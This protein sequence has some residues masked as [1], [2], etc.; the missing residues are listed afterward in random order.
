MTGELQEH[1]AHLQSMTADKERMT[2]ELNIA[3]QIQMNMLPDKFPAFPERSEF[4]IYAT[5]GFVDIGGSNFYDFFLVDKTHFCIVIGDVSGTGIPAT[6]F[7]VITKTH[8][9]ELCTAWLPATGFWQK[10]TIS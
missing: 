8:I 9:G 1:M 4:D 7:A 5:I 10:Q 6:L 2:A 3:R